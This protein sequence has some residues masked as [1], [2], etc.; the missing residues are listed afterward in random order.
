MSPVSDR[1]ER[2]RAAWVLARAGHR[3]AARRRGERLMASA[4]RH[5]RYES[6][7]GDMAVAEVTTRN[8]FHRSVAREDG[9]LNQLGWLIWTVTWMFW[10]AVLVG[11]ALL[12]GKALYGLGALAA[13]RLGPLRSW[14]YLVLA[15]ALAGVLAGAWFRWPPEG[16]DTVVRSYACAQVVLAPVRAAWLVRAWG[17]PAV[18]AAPSGAG[19]VA[20][21]VV[22]APV[23]EGPSPV[24]EEVRVE[25]A[26]VLVGTGQEEEEA[27][28]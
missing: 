12:A 16:W 1:H 3:P 19:A 28:R 6:G 5:E 20:P 7:A 2:E 23:Q 15:L 13:R 27:V 4:R 8:V 24:A 14:P 25:I 21:V 9:V 18:K 17:W 11:P 10:V 22:G 26:P